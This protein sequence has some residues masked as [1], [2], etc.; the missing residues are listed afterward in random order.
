MYHQGRRQGARKGEATSRSVQKS[1]H[2]KH[3]QTAA[4]KSLVHEIGVL[5]GMEQILAVKNILKL[6]RD[7]FVG[8]KNLLLPDL[9]VLGTSYTSTAVHA[10]G[11]ELILDFRTREVGAFTFGGINVGTNQLRLQMGGSLY[12]GIG[13]NMPCG[14]CIW[15]IST[16]LVP[17]VDAS[18]SIPGITELPGFASV[19]VGGYRHIGGGLG[20][21]SH[22]CPFE[23]MSKLCRLLSA[24]A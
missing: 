2:S 18:A 4:F 19:S 13:G 24:P 23:T 14:V 10:A 12:M 6:L 5:N 3:A 22:C 20:V 16:G 15:K 7:F 21:L 8:A 9:L 1:R 17:D 11:A